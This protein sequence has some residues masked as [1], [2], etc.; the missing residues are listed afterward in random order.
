MKVAALAL[1]L[2]KIAP[3]A[4]TQ[5]LNEILLTTN[6][7]VKMALHEM[8]VGVSRV[9][10]HYVKHVINLALTIVLHECLLQLLF[11]I[12]FRISHVREMLISRKLMGYVNGYVGLLE[13]HVM[14]QMSS[15][16][17]AVVQESFLKK[18]VSDALT[19]I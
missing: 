9:M 13:P 8:L 6:A 17:L 16:V 10:E 14:A 18:L 5:I 15:N 11:M 12:P 2:L 19:E 1:G 3:G 4:M 7:S